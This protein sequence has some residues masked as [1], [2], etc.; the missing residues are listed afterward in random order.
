[1]LAGEVAGREEE[2]SAACD[3]AYW[4]DEPGLF[5]HQVGDYEVEFGFLVG[6]GAAVGD[7]LDAELIQAVTHAGA[8]FYLHA[9][10]LVAAFDHEVVAM[11]LSVGLGDHVA[12][13]HG[14]VD[15]GYLAKIA[16]A[17]DA[18]AACLGRLAGRVLPRRSGAS[19]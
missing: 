3:L 9:P 4:Q 19:G 17:S 16:S 6:D 15:E 5:E 12:E 8:G 10:E 1:M 11:H 14:F 2:G 18:E 13:A 7:A